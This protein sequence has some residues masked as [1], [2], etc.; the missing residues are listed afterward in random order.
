MSTSYEEGPSFAFAT[1]ADLGSLDVSRQKLSLS[2]HVAKKCGGINRL[3]K[4]F[5]GNIRKQNRIINQARGKKRERQR[6]EMRS[7]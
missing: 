5:F 3:G 1:H 2:A 6:E 7:I 4:L